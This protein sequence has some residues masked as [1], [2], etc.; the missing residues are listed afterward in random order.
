MGCERVP[1]LGGPQRRDRR[2]PSNGAT[3]SPPSCESC[4]AGNRCVRSTI[5]ATPRPGTN[6]RRGRSCACSATCGPNEGTPPGRFPGWPTFAPS[7][8]RIRAGPLHRRNV[9][10]TRSPDDSTFVGDSLGHLRPPFHPARSDRAA[11][12][13][14]SVQHPMG[15]GRRGRRFVGPLDPEHRSRSGSSSQGSG[16]AIPVP[17]AVFEPCTDLGR[18]S[19]AR[20][21]RSRVSKG[22]S[23]DARR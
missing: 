12:G 13:R 10:S 21:G 15:D 18:S 2:D 4:S 23:F 6:S 11:P 20:S 16:T 1:I 3:S 9:R 8:L 5:V 7:S 19:T 17:G 14:S 22:R